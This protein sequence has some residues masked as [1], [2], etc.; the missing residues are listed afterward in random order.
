MRLQRLQM[1]HCQRTI[2][3]N[4][5]SSVL[6]GPQVWQSGVFTTRF[7]RRGFLLSRGG[8]APRKSQS[9]TTARCVSLILISSQLSFALY[10]CVHCS[11]LDIVLLYCY[12]MCF[13]HCSLAQPDMSVLGV[14]ARRL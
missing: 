3:P 10:N 6:S 1:H 5:V 14:G 7:S 13:I 4:D 11:D 12:V 9:V 8:E 2:E